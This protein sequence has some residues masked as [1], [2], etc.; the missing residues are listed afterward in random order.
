MACDEM[1]L[2]YAYLDAIEEAKRKAQ[3]WECEVTV[4]PPAD[5]TDP[6]PA[7]SKLAGP[8]PAV[9]V[10]SGGT[11]KPSFVCDEPE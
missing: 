2:Y 8:K 9:T 4:I 10:K 1:H 11:A 3:P 7:D 5:D 6:A